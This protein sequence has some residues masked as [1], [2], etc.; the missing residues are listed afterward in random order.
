VRDS[1]SSDASTGPRS[2][3]GEIP[4]GSLGDPQNAKVARLETFVSYVLRWGVLL[5]LTMTS[6][7][8]ILLFVV[9]PSNA[10]VRQTGPFVRHDPAAVLTDLLQLKP[11]A[12]IDAGLILLILT[13]VFRVAVT[14]VAFI[15]D[16]D[17]VYTAIT[18]FVLAVLVASFFLGRVE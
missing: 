6:V 5:S 8:L 13:P 18:L 17:L 4:N 3:S 7:G 10:V 15:L 16:G 11:K 9:D 12:L 2:P 14:V 1:T